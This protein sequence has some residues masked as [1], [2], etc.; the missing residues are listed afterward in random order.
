MAEIT[1]MA[2]IIIPI[3]NDVMKGTKD[4][5]PIIQINKKIDT[6]EKTSGFE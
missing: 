4:T 5:T 2:D 6:I 3:A 1:K